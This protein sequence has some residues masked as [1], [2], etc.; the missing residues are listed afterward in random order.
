M[1]PS[2]RVRLNVNITAKQST[3]LSKVLSHGERTAVFSVLVDE[4]I[5][6]TSNPEHGPLLLNAIIEGHIGIGY[7]NLEGLKDDDS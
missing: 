6:I 7:N 5:R 3:D 2:S 1:P 4:V